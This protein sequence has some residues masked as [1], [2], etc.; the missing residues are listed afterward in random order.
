[1]RTL[2][3]WAYRSISDISILL[4]V[5]NVNSTSCIGSSFSQDVNKVAPAKPK[6]GRARFR[7]ADAS[8]TMHRFDLF[9][10]VL[11]LMICFSVI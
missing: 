8:L 9:L 2:G 10:M 5:L 11:L 3:S 6:T 4:N 1:M 7:K